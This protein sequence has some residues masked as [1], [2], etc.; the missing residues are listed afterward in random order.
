MGSEAGEG[1]SQKAI[2]HER[3]TGE[4]QENKLAQKKDTKK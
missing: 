4:N 3:Q 1:Q 2:L